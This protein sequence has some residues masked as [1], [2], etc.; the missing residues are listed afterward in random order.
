MKQLLK[1]AFLLLAFL[2]HRN[3][4]SKVFYYH[5]VSK[6]FTDMGTDIELMKK[7][8][9]MIKKS[10]YSFVTSITQPQNQV[11][12]CF[13]DGWQGIFENKEVFIKNDIKPTIFIAVSLIGKEGYLTIEQIHI[14]QDM[15][16]QFE[17]HT[18]SH[19]DL[20]TFDND[21]LQS[22]LKES[23]S[24]LE[25]ILGTKLHSICFPM[26][27][28]SKKIIKKCQEYGYTSLYT[29]IPGNFYSLT[30]KGIICRNCAQDLTP[31]ELKWMLFSTSRIYRYKLKKQ[32]VEGKL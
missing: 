29:S 9:E 20:T 13:D 32:Q 11:M 25:T 1:H 5:D 22:E 14:L 26:G 21:H 31:L 8:F 10:G 2:S 12:I 18:W 15:G 30:Q 7:H 16:F 4:G 3:R 23:K 6:K 19:N 28:F 17:C 27:R 24:K